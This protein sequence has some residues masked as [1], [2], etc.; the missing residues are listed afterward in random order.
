M[1]AIDSSVVGNE[2]D[3][4]LL[5]ETVHSNSAIPETLDSKLL[6]PS[7]ERLTE[8]ILPRHSHH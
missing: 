5:L 3:A 1:R 8:T 2:T 7:L 6:V 4:K